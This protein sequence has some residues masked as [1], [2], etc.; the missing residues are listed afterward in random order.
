MPAV[1][2]IQTKLKDQG[3][4]GGEIAVSIVATEEHITI[5]FEGYGD[6]VSWPGHGRPILL[7]LY[8]GVPRVVVWGDIN[9]EDYTDIVTLAGAAESQREQETS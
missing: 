9:Q 1:K 8:N 3:D 4:D 6:R 2:T 7:E 5:A